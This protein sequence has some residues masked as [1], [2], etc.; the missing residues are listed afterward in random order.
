[1]AKFNIAALFDDVPEINTERKQ[2][3][4]IALSR[5]LPDP[6][7]RYELNGIEELAANIEM[8]GLQQPL[9]VRPHEEREG[10]YTITSGHRRRAAMELLSMEEAP[11]I[12]VEACASPALQE[13]RLI[14]AN[15]DTRRMT[16]AEL[17]WQAQRVKE[18]FYALKEE[19]HEF[20]GRMRDHVAAVLQMS[21]SKLGRLEAIQNN[22]KPAGLRKAFELG[23][24]NESTAYEIAKRSVEV[25][26]LA[27]EMPPVFMTCTTEEAL[28]LLD[29][30]ECEAEE[31]AKRKSAESVP[32]INT[33]PASGFN[34]RQ[35]AEEYLEERYAEDAT[36]F[37]LFAKLLDDFLPRVPVMGVDRSENIKA[38]KIA[39]GK[40]GAGSREI[41]WDTYGSGVTVSSLEDKVPHLTRSWSAAYDVL[42]A[43][44]INRAKSNLNNPV[45]KINTGAPEWQTGEPEKS[46]KYYCKVEL[47]GSEMINTL[48]YN[49]GWKL[50]SGG[51]ALDEACTVIGWW[52][53]PEE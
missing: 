39:L 19:G 43:L 2:I 35:R 41:H 9:E 23:Q 22:L 48:I 44:A 15:S 40:R 42:A 6:N 4:Y 7:N 37:K 30:L 11:C 21:K 49:N 31:N 10:Y 17:M 8:F 12:V 20:P 52:P 34:A 47:E 28:K 13:L 18:L 33:A 36:Y 1:M 32:K 27:D 50:L 5:V 16:P 46:G 24:I 38:F 14:F 25:Q 29:K 26:E 53:L 3:E 45:P 51:H